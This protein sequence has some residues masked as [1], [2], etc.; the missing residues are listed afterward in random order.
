MNYYV[1]FQ[2]KTTSCTQARRLSGPAPQTARA[3]AALIFLVGN[4]PDTDSNKGPIVSTMTLISALAPPPGRR[5]AD[6][7]LPESCPPSSVWALRVLSTTSVCA[8]L[9]Q[10]MSCPSWQ[11]HRTGSRWILVRTLPVAPLWCDLG[12]VPNSRGNKAAANLRPVT[13][14]R[15]FENQWRSACAPTPFV[16]NLYRL[17]SEHRA[18]NQAESRASGHA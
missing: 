6:P 15:S 1:K 13:S 5:V 8:S 14:M 18:I 7:K 9:C 11:W 17:S 10:G 2:V 3:A 4:E 12:F 16:I